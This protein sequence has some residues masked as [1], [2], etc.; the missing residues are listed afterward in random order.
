V[1]DTTGAGDALIGGLAAGLAEGLDLVGALRLGM[2][3][4]AVSV[5]RPGAQPSMPA[6][7]D[8]EARMAS[9]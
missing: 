8:V 5:E 9:G 3:A 7:T 6:R 2:A 1:V 4:A